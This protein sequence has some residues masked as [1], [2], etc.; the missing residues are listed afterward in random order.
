MCAPMIYKIV[1]ASFCALHQ[2]RVQSVLPERTGTERAESP[3]TATMFMC[4]AITV[5]SIE[6]APLIVGVG[7]INL[8]SKK[9][10][11]Y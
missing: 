5:I 11:G 3:M 1:G 10:G 4:V 6:I 8:I 7:C 9:G 2:L